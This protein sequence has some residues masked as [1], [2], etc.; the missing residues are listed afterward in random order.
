MGCQVVA[1]ALEIVTDA[2]GLLVPPDDERA[3]AEGLRR[4]IT[5]RE[6]RARLGAAGPARASELCDPARQLA[7]LAAIVAPLDRP[8]VPA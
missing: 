6:T 7:A 8:A 5:D 3:V 2:C 4:L 1:N